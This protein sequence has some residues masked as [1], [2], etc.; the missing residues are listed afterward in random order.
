M[1]QTELKQ[2]H[3]DLR[4]AVALGVPLEVSNSGPKLTASRLKKLESQL[5]KSVSSAS[6]LTQ[7]RADQTGELPARYVA[8]V[9]AFS[10]TKKMVPVLE[11]LSWRT[12]HAKKVSKILLSAL[13]YL[14]LLSLMASAGLLFYLLK[15][16]PE[17]REF[18]TDTN[19]GAANNPLVDPPAHDGLAI[20]N[21]LP[22]VLT[23]LA[24]V[25]A[26][27]FIWIVFF[28]G[29]R[30]LVR[31]LGGTK[32]LN[33]VTKS[34]ILPTI[35]L[36]TESGASRDEATEMACRLFGTDEKFLHN[37]DQLVS[38]SGSRDQ[39]NALAAYYSEIAVQ[40]IHNMNTATRTALVTIVGGA[41]TLCYGLAIFSPIVNLL[42]QLLS[43]GI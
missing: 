2:F 21:V 29:A 32:Y 31:L 10:R 11:G 6:D 5:D 43:K 7:L 41:I 18:D 34:K 26:G 4:A 35:R 3:D 33:S 42:Y 23:V 20:M 40:R 39:T 16:F 36:L 25:L 30:I 27:F 14:A 38:K 1:T 22:T 13:A 8:A 12:I 15:V 19:L 37:I 17:I 28:G 9:E 24:L